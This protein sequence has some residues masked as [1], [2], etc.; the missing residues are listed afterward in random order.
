MATVAPMTIVPEM[1]MSI[2]NMGM[3]ADEAA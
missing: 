2:P 1:G 3:I